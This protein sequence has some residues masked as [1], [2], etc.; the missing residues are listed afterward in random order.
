MRAENARMR[1]VLLLPLLALL[2]GCGPN[3]PENA[4]VVD[5]GCYEIQHVAG[6]HA[7]GQANFS[8]IVVRGDPTEDCPNLA[9]LSFELYADANGNGALDA[10]ESL[11]SG[12]E[13]YT[14]FTTSARIYPTSQEAQR[15]TGPLYYRVVL[16]DSSGATYVS[17]GPCPK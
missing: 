17:E 14:E 1:P 13:E 7:S 10:G 5:F 16:T 2:L 4:I 11:M 3:R 15:G 9:K 8:E 12:S 6:W